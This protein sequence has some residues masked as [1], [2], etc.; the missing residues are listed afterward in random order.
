M[1]GCV[2]STR[3]ALVAI[4]LSL[5]GLKNVAVGQATSNAQPSSGADLA[6]ENQVTA[7]QPIDRSELGDGATHSGSSD[8]AGILPGDKG[9]VFREYDIR[10][11]SAAVGEAKHPETAVIDWILRETGYELWHG[12]TVSFL[13]ADSRRVVAYH[14]P[15][16]QR[17]VRDVVD[18]FVAGAQ[19]NYQYSL[20][21]VSVGHPN[22][23]ARAQAGLRPL[24]IQTPGV[25]A[26]TTTPDGAAQLLGELRRR[27]DYREQTS[28]QLVAINGQTSVLVQNRPIDFVQEMVGAPGGGYVGRPTR[29]DQGYRLELTPLI[30]TDGGFVDTNLKFKVV[31][32]EQLIPVM[33][34]TPNLAAPRARSKIEVP[35][36]AEFRW[37]ESLRWQVGEVLVVSLGLIPSGVV[38]TAGRPLGIP[39]P[40]TSPRADLLL[41]VD[42]RP[43]PAVGVAT[44][45]A[46]VPR[47]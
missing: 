22:W 6:N 41:F 39:L 4:G 40:G 43:V 21:I 37:H 34:D 26:W 3:L 2:R 27:N 45:A 20:Q 18:R 1:N 9:Q 25:Q 47:Y 32:V 14:T 5:F 38:N 11:Y 35:Q 15:E 28:P 8:L 24:A 10:A 17:T 30:S 44:Q 36:V 33:L 31:E 16:V 13:S 7:M 46:G 29:M 19:R 12:D 42:G 23:R